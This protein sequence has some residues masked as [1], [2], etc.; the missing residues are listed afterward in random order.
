M[1]DTVRH[2]GGRRG[3]AIQRAPR[4]HVSE[5]GVRRIAWQDTFLHWFAGHSLGNI[6]F[7]PVATM[8]MQRRGSRRWVTDDRRHV[9]EVVVLLALVLVTTAGVF[10]QSS[11]PLLFLPILPVILTT[12]RAGGLGAAI[13]IV[14]VATVA[15]GILTLLHRG[16][17]SLM[18]ATDG[19]R[20]QFFP[21]LSGDDRPDDPA[22]R[23]RPRPPA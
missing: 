1:A 16:P 20:I 21:I 9:V 7:A 3:T 12:F 19:A 4:R 23:G 8:L 14:I 13:S 11:L 2:P 6:T 10:A 15:G 17:I 5:G 18:D 22:G